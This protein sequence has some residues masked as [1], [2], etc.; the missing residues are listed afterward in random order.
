MWQFSDI[1]TP[2]DYNCHLFSGQTRPFRTLTDTDVLSQTFNFRCI[3]L[4]EAL[5][6]KKS[7]VVVL[8][9]NI[10]TIHQNAPPAVL[11]P[12]IWYTFSIIFLH[13][14]N[15]RPPG[16]SPRCC[17]FQKI[18]ELPFAKMA[19]SNKLYNYINL[20]TEQIWRH[21]N[22]NWAVLRATFL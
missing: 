19:L 18:A 15:F 8:D 9:M 21:L 13:R 10:S 20:M 12:H 6:K 3:T 14:P 4:G 16:S 5:K 17:Q 2:S 22:R 7:R 1:Y 11:C